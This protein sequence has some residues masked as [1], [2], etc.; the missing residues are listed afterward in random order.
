M[1]SFEASHEFAFYSDFVKHIVQHRSHIDI[2]DI[3]DPVL[4][5]RLANILRLQKGE[6]IVLFNSH[7]NVRCEIKAIDSKKNL[8]TVELHEIEH[9]MHIKPHITW[10]LPLLKREAF[11]ESLYILTALGVQEIQP[12]LTEKT[13]KI[14]F[15]NQ[16]IRNE[17]IMIAAAEQSKQFILPQINPIITLDLWLSGE[18]DLGCKKVFFDKSGSTL[19]DVV[20]DIKLD[21]SVKIYAFVGP[22]GDLTYQE[23]IQLAADG[24]VF[25]ALGPT[26]LRAEHAITVG[27]G[28]LRSLL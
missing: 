27:L 22:E 2:Q 21:H 1:K 3:T 20:T 13:R 6:F 10:L 15:D 12:I 25:C 26:V 9:N 14:A 5:N 24:F 4:V 7:H 23:K 17:K 16:A 18:H 19:Q 8:V 11:E 28:A